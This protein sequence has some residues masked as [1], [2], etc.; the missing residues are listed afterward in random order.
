MTNVFNIGCGAYVVTGFCERL[1]VNICGG[2]TRKQSVECEG[3]EVSDHTSL[4][5]AT[6]GDC[7]M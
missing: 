5:L 6:G 2:R 4:L 7:E 3:E 1:A